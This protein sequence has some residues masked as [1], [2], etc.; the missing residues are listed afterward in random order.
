[1]PDKKEVDLFDFVEGFHKR[2][3][4]LDD[5]QQEAESA[6]EARNQMAFLLCEATKG[7]PLSAPNNEPTLPHDVKET[8]VKLLLREEIV[9]P[10]D[11]NAAKSWLSKVDDYCPL[12]KEREIRWLRMDVQ[13]FASERDAVLTLSQRMRYKIRTS[14]DAIADAYEEVKTS[15]ADEF[16]RRTSW[17]ALVKLVGVFKDHWHAMSVAEAESFPHDIDG[18]L[19]LNV[20][21]PGLN[22]VEGLTLEESRPNSNNADISHVRISIDCQFCGAHHTLAENDW[23]GIVCTNCTRT[24]RRDSKEWR[25]CTGCDSFHRFEHYTDDDSTEETVHHLTH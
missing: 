19:A 1:M 24:I 12:S 18:V 4:M 25:T 3:E 2:G 6:I 16:Y 11:L 9:Y 17:E 20:F 5:A 7:K 8:L 14:L 22:G 10:D 13:K 23:F 21:H 15:K